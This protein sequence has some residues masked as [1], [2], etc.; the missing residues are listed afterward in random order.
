MKFGQFGSGNGQF[1]T[2]IDIAIDSY[3][4]VYVSDKDN[5]R[6][7]V[8]DNNGTYIT[9]FGNSGTASE[10]IHDPVGIAINSQGAVYVADGINT[11]I[12]V[13]YPIP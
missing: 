5:Q 7:Q 2:P 3:N 9:Q 10:L 4:N 6:I 11:D 13:Y 1:R 8:F 12:H